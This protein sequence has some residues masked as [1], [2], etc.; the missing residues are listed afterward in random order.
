MS[1]PARVI[2][3]T[4]SHNAWSKLSFAED[5]T[6]S[7][8]PCKVKDS[9]GVGSDLLP[10]RTGQTLSEGR[11]GVLG[12]RRPGPSRMQIRA[13]ESG[14]QVLAES[15]RLEDETQRRA[16]RGRL[17]G[18]LVQ[19]VGVFRDA[20]RSV[21]NTFDLTTVFLQQAS[22]RAI[23]FNFKVQRLVTTGGW[24]SGSRPSGSEIL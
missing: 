1:L 19:R 6:H 23:G 8:L 10:V 4:C 5:A 3:L 9:V 15:R 16:E 17:T 18:E 20:V 11:E 21:R 24:A 22:K 2:C 13:G 7:Q 14:H 12:G